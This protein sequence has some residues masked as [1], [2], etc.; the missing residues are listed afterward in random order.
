[1]SM[2]E[3]WRYERPARSFSFY[4]NWRNYKI[5]IGPSARHMNKFNLFLLVF[6]S[7]FTS[8]NLIF[9]CSRRKQKKKTKWS[10]LICALTF[11]P[12]TM[13]NVDGTDSRLTECVAVC[14]A[15]ICFVFSRNI[16]KT[17]FNPTQHTHTQT[18]H[19]HTYNLE[20]MS[21]P[22]TCNLSST[23]T[24]WHS[25]SAILL[26][27][28]VLQE[29]ADAGAVVVVDSRWRSKHMCDSHCVPIIF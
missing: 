4:V 2:K 9:K 12:C 15:P 26:F 25:L 7:R 13:F 6:V 10:G 24:H 17:P 22:F 21:A 18:I 29:H 3:K 28:F 16:H 14:V 5:A 11:E 8:T 19:S 23:H 27:R 20:R 1:M